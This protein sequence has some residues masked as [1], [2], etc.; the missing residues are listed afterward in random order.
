M[1]G[2]QRE[3]VET[4]SDLL[5]LAEQHVAWLD[6]PNNQDCTWDWIEQIAWVGKLLLRVVEA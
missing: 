4:K 6:L 5:L 1:V 3:V 2:H